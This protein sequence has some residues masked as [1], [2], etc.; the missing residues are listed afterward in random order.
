MHSINITTVI[1]M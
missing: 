1:Y